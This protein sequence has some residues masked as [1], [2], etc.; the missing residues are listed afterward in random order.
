VFPESERRAP[1]YVIGAP[2]LTEA[3]SIALTRAGLQARAIDGEASSL[4]GLSWLHREL[5]RRA[6]ST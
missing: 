4:A 6:E 5:A 1:V 2:H 3:Y